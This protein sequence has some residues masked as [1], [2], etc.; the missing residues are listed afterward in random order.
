MQSKLKRLTEKVGRNVTLHDENTVGDQKQDLGNIVNEE[1]DQDRKVS[2]PAL[3]KSEEYPAVGSC[4]DTN[5]H[6]PKHLSSEFVEKSVVV[7]NVKKKIPEGNRSCNGNTKEEVETKKI[8]FSRSSE[9][10]GSTKDS[11]D[12]E[13][14]VSVRLSESGGSTKD[15]EDSENGKKKVSVQ[16]SESG[17]SSKELE[18]NKDGEKKVSVRPQE[19]GDSISMSKE[20]IDVKNDTKLTA[21]HLKIGDLKKESKGDD[22]KT[23]ETKV[24]TRLSESGDLM[25]KS[26]EDVEMDHNDNTFVSV[27]SKQSGDSTSNLKEGEEVEKETIVSGDAL[28]KSKEDV[29]M[30]EKELAVPSPPLFS[31]NSTVKETK[32]S[33]RYSESGESMVGSKNGVDM[34]K[35]KTN[36]LRL[37]ASGESLADTMVGDDSMKDNSDVQSCSKR[38][39]SDREKGAV[40]VAS[41]GNSKPCDVDDASISLISDEK[42]Q[43]LIDFL[44]F[45][46]SHKDYY[47]FERAIKI[48]VIIF[49]PEFPRNKTNSHSNHTIFLPI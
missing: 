24:P 40:S 30:M 14:K 41:S 7:A 49:F 25:S 35:E 26:K 23:K 13:K 2:S 38:K 18:N 1:S 44:D 15:V 21:K 39:F 17:R 10:G 42:S 45:I 22:E 46:R 19:S 5:S 34:E 4:D 9:S 47:I 12:G 33:I 36:S 20:G 28:S 3:I 16:L 43:P 32:V 29:E 48:Q 27:R 8:E 37:P 6:E 31:D 11:E